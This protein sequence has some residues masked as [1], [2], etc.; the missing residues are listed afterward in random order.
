MGEPSTAQLD[1]MR[2]LVREAMEDGALGIG[3][4]LIYPPGSFASTN[5]L[6][7]DAKAMAP[8]G[9]VYISQGAGI[10]ALN[11]A[12]RRRPQAAVDRW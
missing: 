12:F 1:T 7:E 10:Q 6:I 4:A 8:Y 5:E 9:G 3:S 2:R 11:E